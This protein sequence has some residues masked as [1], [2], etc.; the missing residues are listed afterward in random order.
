MSEFST[1]SFFMWG[2]ITGITMLVVGFSYRR[3]LK[4]NNPFS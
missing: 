3:Y 4:K 1:I 2:V